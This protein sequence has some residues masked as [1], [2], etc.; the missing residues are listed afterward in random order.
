MNQSQTILIDIPEGRYGIAREVATMLTARPTDRVI[1]SLL[2]KPG[3]DRSD[4]STV[5]TTDISWMSD[6][7]PMPIHNGQWLS[8]SISPMAN[9]SD[10]YAELTGS[11]GSALLKKI[12]DGHHV[13]WDGSNMVG[14]ITDAA[15]KA[16]E[17]LEDLLAE[18]SRIEIWDAADYA[19]D[20]DAATII[21]DGF[22]PRDEDSL[23]DWAMTM[24]QEDEMVLHSVRRWAADFANREN[25]DT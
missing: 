23:V 9:A 11:E 24:S 22:D 17:E 19:G 6:G 16:R 4:D 2:I 25:D 1:A 3:S 15:Q 14:T 7:T 5:V 13:E 10:I 21:A 20:T 8:L 18:A 12:V